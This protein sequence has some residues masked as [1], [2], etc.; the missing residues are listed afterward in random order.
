MV[1]SA[2]LCFGLAWYFDQ[3]LVEGAKPQPILFLLKP[4]YWA[5]FW[6]R[7]KGAGHGA[8][9][10]AALRAR[11]EATHELQQRQ[12]VST[13]ATAASG[14]G[15]GGGGG[16]G[17]TAAAAASTDGRR[18]LD[19]D[20]AA[21]AAAVCSRS[22]V[23]GA[24]VELLD[25]R[26][27][28]SSL[29]LRASRGRFLALPRLYRRSFA[30]VKGLSVSFHS[31]QV[32]ALLGHNG[33]G[34]TTTFSMVAAQRAPSGGDV[35]VHGLSVKEEAP[36]VRTHLG[37]CPQHDIL[38]PELTAREHLEL[39]GSL[40]GMSA[41]ECAR[42]VPGLLR[43]V[44]GRRPSDDESPASLCAPLSFHSFLLSPRARPLLSPPLHPLPTNSSRHFCR[45]A[46]TASWPTSPP[47]ASRAACSGG[48]QLRAR[49]SATPLARPGVSRRW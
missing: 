40:T 49:S 35:S 32:F 13:E 45:C 15:G 22:G 16:G 31:G 30:A 2:L 23:P 4:S 48:S 36:A 42:C 21:E 24:S 8:A 19:S 43:Q 47:A 20:V 6:A 17:T 27:V 33:A 9:A 14:G 10:L 29:A 46:S 41:E 37:I 12:R 39:Y 18:T 1:L 26:C 34:K 3:I 7:G 44:E 28:F 38:Y 25:L 5:S 11:L